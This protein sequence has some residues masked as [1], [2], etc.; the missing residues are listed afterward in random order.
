MSDTEQRIRQ[1]AYEL[2]EQAGRPDDHS[3]R[4]W[5][6]ARQEIEGDTPRPGNQPGGAIDDPPDARSAAEPP[7][8][9][10]ATGVPGELPPKEAEAA[11]AAVPR[12]ARVPQELKQ[13]A[14][15]D[16]TPPGAATGKT[17]AEGTVLTATASSDAEPA[18]D[19]ARTAA[20]GTPRK[21]ADAEPA[22]AP[23]KPA[24]PAAPT[25]R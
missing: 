10:V 24:T 6:A 14:P 13:T 5:F 11:E 25:R 18:N 9:S 17:Q 7:T 12:A 22:T 8:L 19:R 21:A 16:R 3:D 20:S 2:W 23:A 15:N 1:R 4:F